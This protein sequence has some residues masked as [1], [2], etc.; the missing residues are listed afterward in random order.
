MP[1]RGQLV[2]FLRGDRPCAG[3]VDGAKG[4]R[5]LVVAADGKRL[6]VQASAV[7]AS[8]PD[9]GS[10]RPREHA[11]EWDRRIAEI[12]ESISTAEIWELLEGSGEMSSRQIEEAWFGSPPGFGDRA[13]LLATLWNDRIYF[14]RRKDRLMPE[15]RSL[16]E[17]RLARRRDHERKAERIERLS[18]AARTIAENGRAGQGVSDEEWKGFV[19]ALRD[20]AVHGPE[21]GGT[22]EA[23]EILR[24]ASLNPTEAPFDL[25]V[26]IGEFEPDENLDL[27]RHGVRASFPEGVL[28]EAGSVAGELADASRWRREREDASGLGA[29]TI[30]SER[31][32]EVD[33]ALSVRVLDEGWEIGV[34]IADVTSL[35]SLDGP[36]VRE[37]SARGT[38]LYMPEGSVP[39]MPPGLGRGGFSLDQ[40]LDRPAMS[41]FA[42]VGP[43]GDVRAHRFART[44]VCVARR[45]SYEEADDLSQRGD[46]V[47]GPLLEAGG[48]LRRR[49][50]AQ[51]GMAL[52]LPELDVRVDRS[53][54]IHVAVV[55]GSSPAH[56]LV[57]ECAILYNRLAAG[58][59]TGAGLAAIFRVQ[60]EPPEELPDTLA[61]GPAAELEARRL[62]PPSSFTTQPGPH[63]T[64]GVKAY[65]L[66]TSPIRRSFDLYMQHQ[67]AS[68]M[69]GGE[70]LSRDDLDRVLLVAGPAAETMA[71]IERAR[72]RY[73]VLRYLDVQH[74]GRV[75]SGVVVDRFSDRILVHLV[76]F[77]LE[78]ILR[79]KEPEAFRK[80][81]EIE[82]R[83]D[84][85]DARRDFAR[86]S[87]VR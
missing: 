39:M 86:V 61:G 10:G 40:G 19:D 25:L 49:R 68:A 20:L 17:E 14:A 55:R 45:L 4:E 54:E 7:L 72:T 51:G 78:V 33:D 29:V 41:L 24:R 5:I 28:E 13:A 2:L 60:P 65:T 35:L 62:L 30:D 56:V 3:V 8:G 66:A 31:T 46:P 82:V 43:E 63:F 50:L 52:S 64:L 32:V 22:G 11:R 36:V 15:P 53:G 47:L 85:A 9:V 59:V 21:A 83:L 16:V 70:P 27:I 38:S 26:A 67:I 1:A 18:G 58:H 23:V 71:R 74:R 87:L 84:R 73:W 80:G 79:T 6:Q 37:A 48:V 81:E 69:G 12:G 75:L 44:T 77:A 42:R 76:D 34:H 57:S